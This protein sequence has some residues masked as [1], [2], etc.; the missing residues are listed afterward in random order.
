MEEGL[1]LW[2]LEETHNRLSGQIH[3]GVSVSSPHC[4]GLKKAG[5]GSP[6]HGQVS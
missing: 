2:N 3:A 5:A 1:P 4:L 6:Q